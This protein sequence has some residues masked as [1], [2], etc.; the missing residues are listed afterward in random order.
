MKDFWTRENLE[1]L[2]KLLFFV[3]NKKEYSG[4][5]QNSFLDS[6][7]KFCKEFK[8]KP[9]T[10]DFFVEKAYYEDKVVAN[11]YDFEEVPVYYEH[12]NTV[13]VKNPFYNPKEKELFLRLKFIEIDAEL[14]RK[15][16][17]LGLPS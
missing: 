16:L 17:V 2:S 11:F 10:P 15:F 9:G 6:W 1:K 5:V 12:K 8:I 14:A 13:V 3:P 4:L 7:I